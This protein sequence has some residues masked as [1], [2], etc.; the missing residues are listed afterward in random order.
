MS[1]SEAARELPL[2]PEER[3][4]QRLRIYLLEWKEHL[5]AYRPRL[6]APGTAGY[7]VGSD[8]GVSTASE[9]LERSDLWAMDVIERGIDDLRKRRDGEALRAALMVRLLNLAIPAA[10]FRHGRLGGLAPGEL[11]GLADRAEWELVP[12]VKLLGLPL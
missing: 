5:A 6:G 7:L 3:E 4:L 1:L 11:D 2:A 12:I 10:V 9:W 8:S